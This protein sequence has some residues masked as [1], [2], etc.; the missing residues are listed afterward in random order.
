D[1]LKTIS[2]KK[3]KKIINEIRFRLKKN[4]QENLDY[5]NKQQ[6]LQGVQSQPKDYLSDQEISKL[7]QEL[8]E[9]K[10]DL[11]IKNQELMTWL[12][13]TMRLKFHFGTFLD[14]LICAGGCY[15][16]VKPVQI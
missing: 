9:W 13:Q 14:D 7:E 12:I 5:V 10:S 8:K 15:Y 11:E 16:Q 6:Q 1:V 4:L 3:K 2:N